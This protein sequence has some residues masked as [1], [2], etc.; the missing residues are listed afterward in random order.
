MVCAVAK[1]HI[2]VHGPAEA[3]GC[4]DFQ[5]PRYHQRPCG[6]L[7]SVLLPEP[8]LMSMARLLQGTVLVSVTPVVPE[9]V[10]VSWPLLL[11]RTM[12]VFVARAAAEGC[13]YVFGLYYHQRP[14]CSPWLVLRLETTWM[15]VVH[16]VT[17]N[18]AEVYDQCSH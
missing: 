1:G 18:H 2:W 15:S 6:C 5:G 4:V 10:L 3:G 11:Q 17:G 8:A 16:A 7:W 12:M 9:A 13:V 14:C